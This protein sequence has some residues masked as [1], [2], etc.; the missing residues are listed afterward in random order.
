MN[1]P[2]SRLQVWIRS[3]DRHIKRGKRMDAK[4][5]HACHV[6]AVTAEVEEFDSNAEV[7]RIA[8]EAKQTDWEVTPGVTISGYGYN[9]QVP[10]PIIEAKQGVPLEI[11]FTNKLME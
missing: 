8:L 6:P 10:G 4:N 11:T 1:R 3:N 2:R 5:H 7:I 9:G